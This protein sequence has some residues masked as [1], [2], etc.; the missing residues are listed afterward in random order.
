MKNCILQVLAICA[1]SFCAAFAQAKVDEKKWK[2]LGDKD[3]AIQ[4]YKFRENEE[5]V[6]SLMT[7]SNPDKTVLTDASVD[8]YVKAMA[9]TRQST[10][11]VLGREEWQ[12]TRYELM[13]GS[14]LH[15]EG[16]YVEDGKE[17]HFFEVNSLAPDKYAQH[18]I[19]EPRGP[20]SVKRED[21]L[22]ILK[23]AGTP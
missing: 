4:V 8:E 10:A 21:A 23:E 11:R 18:T 19:V 6:L 13:P 12:I 16:K 3:D 9:E 22:A 15:V 7:T 14:V 1:L 5:R 2:A 17:F 20:A